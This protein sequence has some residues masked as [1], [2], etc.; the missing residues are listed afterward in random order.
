LLALGHNSKKNKQTNNNNN[1]KNQ[2]Q[3]QKKTVVFE[4]QSTDCVCKPLQLSN[5][6]QHHFSSLLFLK[7]I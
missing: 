4:K 7:G 5:A 6:E 1:N 3:N 2:N